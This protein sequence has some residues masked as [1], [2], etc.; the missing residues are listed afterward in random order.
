M[1]PA[2]SPCA[3]VGS[4]RARQLPPASMSKDLLVR[5]TGDFKL[6]KGVK[7]GVNDRLFVCV[8]PVRAG[9]GSSLLMTLN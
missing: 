6:A 2:C 8:S 4:L 9:I 5:L 1:E 7:V 3:C